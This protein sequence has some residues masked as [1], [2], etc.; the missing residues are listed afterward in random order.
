MGRLISSAADCIIADPETAFKIDALDQDQLKLQTKIIVGGDKVRWWQ[1]IHIDDIW[2]TGWLDQLGQVV[3]PEFQQAHGGQH[4][5]G[6]HD[7]DLLHQRD[8]RKAQDG[9]PHPQLLRVLSWRDGQVLAGPHTWWRHVV[10]LRH[11]LGKVFLVHTVWSMVTGQYSLHT[12]YA[13]V[14]ETSS[15]LL[16]EILS[17]SVP[18]R[19]RHGACS[20]N[21]N[22]TNH[23]HL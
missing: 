9:W 8:H 16:G 5:Q 20:Y 19:P 3:W 22:V 11:W 21:F 7:A 13:K 15:L 10:H 14:I 17:S 1:I 18:G 23:H 4:P 2:T 12:R 6:R